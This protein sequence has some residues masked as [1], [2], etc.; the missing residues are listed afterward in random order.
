MTKRIPALLAAL[1]AIA[2]LQGCVE[3]AV[4]G[5]GAGVM[6][7]VDR[8]TTGTQVEDE[9]IELRASNRIG[10]RF[11]DRAHVNVKAFNRNVL[12]TGEVSDAT[13]RS[14]VERIARGVPSVRSVTNEV[15]VA[16]VS[17]YS[18]RASDATVTGKVKARFLDANKFNAIHVKV[19]T[20]AGVVYLMGLVTEREG[21]D[22]TEIARTTS[23]VRKV[24]K[25]F[26]YCTTAEEACRPR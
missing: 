26:E 8:R 5:A 25:V 11:G 19:V 17:A 7:V 14:E 6:S 9:G 10:E 3:M 22:A 12:L 24:V 20:E 15:Q 23:G 21:A 16:G 18:A 13:A 2:T 4:V 1:S